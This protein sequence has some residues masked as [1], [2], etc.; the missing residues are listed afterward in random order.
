MG[1]ARRAHPAEVRCRICGETYRLI[2]P[3][4]LRR[5]GWTGSNPG[6][7]YKARFGVP[8]LWSAAS[9]RALSASLTAS[10]DRRGRRWTRRGL[11]Q[12]LR[13]SGAARYRDAEPRVYWTAQRLFGSWKAA[14]RAAGLPRARWDAWPAWT[15]GRVIREIRRRRDVHWSAVPARLYNAGQRLFGRWAAA[16]ARAGIPLERRRRRPRWSRE[17]VLRALRARARAGRSLSSRAV[18]LD[19]ARLYK[20]VYRLFPRWRAATARV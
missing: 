18:R 9:R 17:D 2:T 3:S 8:T 13:R 5:H 6:L 12:A 16:L 15:P 19:D 11:L 10:H 4:H 14:C 20:A 7:A 1:R